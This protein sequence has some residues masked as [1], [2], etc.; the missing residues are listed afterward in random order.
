MRSPVKA[1]A[2]SQLHRAEGKVARSMNMKD[3]GRS[4]NTTI[5]KSQ[6]DFGGTNIE[7]DQAYSFTNDR[8]LERGS[9]G[10]E[11]RFKERKFDHVP[12]MG[13]AMPEKDMPVYKAFKSAVVKPA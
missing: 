5:K 11:S 8:H 12:F 2:P 1:F 13:E 7:L 3:S 4:S 6:V 9:E 10:S